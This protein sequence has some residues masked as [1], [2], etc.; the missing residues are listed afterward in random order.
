MPDRC[1]FSP[2]IQCAIDDLS[3]SDRDGDAEAAERLHGLFGQFRPRMV[4][5]PLVDFS[6]LHRGART[7]CE[8]SPVSALETSEI[9]RLAGQYGV[10]VRT[11]GCGHTLNGSSL[12]RHGELLVSTRALIHARLQSDGTIYTG[13]GDVLWHVDS[14]IRAQGCALPVVND[15]YAGPS[16]GGYVAA[17]GFGPGSRT[18]GGFWENVAE[19]TVV[20]GQGAIHRLSR[21][22]PLFPWL[23]GSMG[24]LGIIVEARLETVPQTAVSAFD[25]HGRLTVD[26]KPPAA[27]QLAPSAQESPDEAGKL[28]WFTLFVDESHLDDAHARLDSLEL[29]YSTVFTFLRRYAYFIAHR[30]TAAPLI[31]PQATPFYAVGSWGTPKDGVSTDRSGVLEFDTEF[32]EMALAHGYRRYVQSEVPCGPHLYER[33]FGSEVYS[34][35]RELKQH[36]DPDH[37]LNRGWVFEA[38]VR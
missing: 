6:R 23:F 25:D 22:A 38:H 35:F 5:G 18:A 8:V 21:E 37:L 32:T 19:L 3:N 13:A 34:R 33:C 24:Q 27:E 2:G 20:D 14:L 11:R 26:S 31:W 29:R 9:V 36:Q 17:G 28:F 15:G 4:K 12:P 7:F 1:V 10:P 30:H 16:V